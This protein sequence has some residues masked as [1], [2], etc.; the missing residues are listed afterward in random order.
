MKIQT[1]RFGEFK[2]V[3]YLVIELP[4]GTNLKL[5]YNEVLKGLEI[6]KQDGQDTHIEII[7][8]VSN[9]IIVK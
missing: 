5:R 6:N 1:E 4:D 3:K 2:E 7:P 8:R 9:E